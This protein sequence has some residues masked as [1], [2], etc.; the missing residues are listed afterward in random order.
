M[1]F[2]FEKTGI[3]GVI[4]VEPRVFG[5]E[6]GFFMESY[7]ASE[8]KAN[9][10]DINF[11]Q[12]N[13]SKSTK[14]VLRGLHFQKPP[15]QQAKLVRCIKGKIFDVAVDLRAGSKTFGQWVGAE[16]SEEN[17]KMLYIPEGFAHGFVAL[18]EEAEVLYKASNEYSAEHDTGVRWDDPDIGVNWGIDNPIISEKDAN[19]LF[20]KDIKEELKKGI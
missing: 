14:N 6:R 19:M 12:D 18:S 5:D 20:L 9:G 1:P 3:G 16:L 11:L 10:I 4:L 2:N 17:K 15:K 13:H 8:F 7:K